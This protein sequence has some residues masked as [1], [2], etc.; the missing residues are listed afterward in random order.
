MVI[1][2]DSA[3][4]ISHEDLKALGVE[5]CNYPM[6]V[7]GEPIDVSMDMSSEAKDEIRAI[8][9]DKNR[10]VS[11]SGL[12]E[13][14]LLE[15]YRRHADEPILSVHQST[16][17][18][19]ASAQVIAKII[20]EHPEMDITHYDA[21]HLVSGYSIIIREAA[22]RLR[23][24]A[25]RQEMDRFLTAAPEKTRHYGVLYDLFYLSRTGRIGKAKAAMGT[26]MKIIPILSATDP[27]GDLKS[28]GK[29]KKYPQAIRKFTELVVR[30]RERWPN[31]P[32]RALVSYIGPHRTEA[33]ELKAAVEALGGDVE[34]LLYGTNHSN[35][36]HAGPDYFDIGYMLMES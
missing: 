26:A 23:N 21:R 33:E 15:I 14:D 25:D 6:Y 7:D 27:P 10:N 16:R 22:L 17:A 13:D 9:K 24:G 35:M 3:V 20:R 31:A 2:A 28:L 30:D 18:S 5:V 12:R 34:V 36:P 1:V 11:T 19:T 29:V 4:Q 32:L 8:L